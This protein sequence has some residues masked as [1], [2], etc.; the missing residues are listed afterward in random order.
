MYLWIQDFPGE[1]APSQRGHSHQ[2]TPS[3]SP[4]WVCKLFLPSQCPSNI[5]GIP[6]NGDE[7]VRCE[8]TLN[9]GVPNYY[10]SH[11]FP[12]HCLKLKQKGRQG[13][14]LAA[15]LDPPLWHSFLQRMPKL[16]QSCQ[17]LHP[18]LLFTHLARSLNT[19][20]EKPITNLTISS[21]L[22][23]EIFEIF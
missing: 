18:Y 23:R 19:T 16:S 12:E 10:F 8:Q 17:W 3:L 15:L 5:K 7:V 9:V 4:K 22:F 1:E 11:F 13:K 6:V 20:L 14:F 21:A 2:T